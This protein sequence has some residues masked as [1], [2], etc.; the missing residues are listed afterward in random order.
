MLDTNICIYAMKNK[1]ASVLNHL[2]KNMNTGLCI[3]TITLAEL[4]HGVCKSASRER[5]EVALLKFLALLKVLP[6]DESAAVEY[7]RI[8]AY[9][10]SL[11]TP[12]GPMD[13]LIAAHALSKSLVLVTNN[14]REFERVPNLAIENWSE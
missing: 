12:I 13:T 14:V 2:R 11:G 10:Q 7:G 4:E 6:F 1:P 8:C 3:S 9:L 5:N